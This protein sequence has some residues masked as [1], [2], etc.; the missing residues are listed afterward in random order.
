MFFADGVS[1]ENFIHEP[2]Y[3]RYVAPVLKEI[4]SNYACMSETIFR[5]YEK[6]STEYSAVSYT[7]LNRNDG[8]VFTGS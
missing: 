6:G 5:S 1:T 3:Q 8:Y 2:L 7:H 4:E